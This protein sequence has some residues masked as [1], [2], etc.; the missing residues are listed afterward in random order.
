MRERNSFRLGFVAV[1][2]CSL[3][4]ACTSA[5]TSTPPPQDSG[6]HVLEIRDDGERCFEMHSAKDGTDGAETNSTTVCPFV[7]FRPKPD[8]R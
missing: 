7:D 8:G 1:S 5:V 4:A 3:I 2:L 6:V